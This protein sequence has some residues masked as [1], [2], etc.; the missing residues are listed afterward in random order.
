M[1]WRRATGVGAVAVCTVALAACSSQPSRYGAASSSARF[2]DA[3][4]G[5]YSSPRLIADGEPVPRGGGSYLIGHPYTIA[6]HAYY[7]TE[8]VEGYSVV[9]TA[10]WYGDAFTAAG[11][12]TARSSTRTRSRQPIR[13]CRCRATCA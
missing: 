6:G 8:R 11:P 1:L 7:P 2:F 9:G 5:V 3:R 4:L 12:P 13:P 10:S